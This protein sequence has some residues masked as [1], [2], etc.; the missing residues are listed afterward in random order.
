MKN[1]NL[2]NLFHVIFVIGCFFTIPILADD[3]LS[4]AVKASKEGNVDGLIA[5][6]SNIITSDADNT[7]LA[8]AYTMLA[9]GFTLKAEDNAKERCL[10][11]I[12]MLPKAVTET[13]APA[14]IKLLSG[15]IKPGTMQEKLKGAPQDWQAVGAVAKYLDGV[16]RK[17]KLKE[18]YNYTQEY[19]NSIIGLPDNWAKVWQLRLIAWHKWVQSGKGDKDKL[20]KLI[21]ENGA[22]TLIKKPES[23][24]EEDFKSVC[25]VIKLYLQNKPKDAKAAAVKAKTKYSATSDPLY[26]VLDYLSG[27]KTITQEKIFDSTSSKASVWALAT[28]AMFA[29]SLSD[30]TQPNKQMLYYYI[31]N[32]NGNYKFLKKFPE[33]TAWK[34][35][36]DR[37]RKW[38]D[39]GFKKN[40]VGGLEPLLIARSGKSGKQQVASVSPPKEV[41]QDISTMEL[42]EFEKGR[43]ELYGKRPRP[44]SMDFEDSDFKRYLQTLP[45][46]KKPMEETRYKT[47]K[48]IKHFIVRVL[49][50]S[51]YPKGL[52]TK[53]G[54][55]RGVVYMANTNILRLKKST[56]SRKGKSYKWTDLAFEQYPAFMEYFAKRRLGI[57][58]A[59]QKTR[60]QIKED[61]AMEYLGMAMLCD[62]FGKYEDALKYAKR[63]IEI[64]PESKNK[65]SNMM[66]K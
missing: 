29:K 1:N 7:T 56:R 24:P 14:I 8:K 2:F 9:L 55:K 64:S 51:P 3:S 22:K 43:E 50:R 39:S 54:T 47:V 65:I 41:I 23:Q 21:A 34:T 45:Q 25:E 12:D 13:P 4:N 15:E 48:D 60:K 66:L 10:F 52:I 53:R 5:N 62:W 17:A 18:L 26:T 30:S 27:N 31:D 28:I 35:N 42:E 20:E 32:Y 57:S 38:L 58:G 40:A 16:R 11:L 33:V 44:A 63:A 6:C 46:D 61:A 37:W 49:E 36:V 59:G 19:K